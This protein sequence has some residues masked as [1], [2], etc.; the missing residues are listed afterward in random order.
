MAEPLKDR[1]DAAVVES[2]GS[3]IEGATEAADRFDRTAFVA[4]CLDGL[5]RLELT[6]RIAHVA[7]AMGDHLP[8]DRERA[9]RILIDSLPPVRRSGDPG[10]D[11]GDADGRSDATMSEFALWPYSDFVATHGHDHLE[12]AFELQYEVTK[13]FTSEFSMRSFLVG[14]HRDATLE[15]LRQWADDPD[16]HVRR[17]VSESTRP[18]LPWAR[19]LDE[20][21]ADPA[22]V[23]DLL[24]LLRHDRSEYVRRS[25]ANNLNDIAKDHPDVTIAVATRWW[26]ELP[27]PDGSDHDTRDQ[28][29]AERR[30]IR[31]AL[32]TLIKRGDPAAL[33]VLGFGADS[34]ARLTNATIEPSEVAIGGSV[35]ISLEVEN[36]A[37]RDAP[38][39][40]ALV[41]IVV[42]F[43]KAD[44]SARPKVFKG[45]ELRLDPGRRSTVTKTI[46][47]KQLSTRT[48]HPGIHRVDALVNGVEIECGHF[49]LTS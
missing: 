45:S 7:A 11:P 48:H 34:P 46:S 6:P 2:L 5:D 9:L 22:P 16:A 36:P 13:R 37:D 18:R 25:V 47:L 35:R 10:R 20:F 40:G 30:M 33:G 15:R 19:R 26:N 14:R 29:V 32:R 42:H 24:E 23:V 39:A 1:F 21:V 28:I 31:H 44:G 8:V 4:Q 43:V 49:T 27:D 12:T 41:D 17:L 3:R 38:P